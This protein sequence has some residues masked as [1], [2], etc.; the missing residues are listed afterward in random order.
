MKEVKSWFLNYR[1]QIIAIAVIELLILL[2]GIFY[3]EAV[4]PSRSVLL[5]SLVAMVLITIFALLICR[6]SQTAEKGFR[7]LFLAAMIVLGAFYMVVFPPNS[8]PDEIYHFQSSYKCADVL[9]GQFVNSKEITIRNADQVLFEDADQEV[10][11]TH[12]RNVI[13]NAEIFA[14]EEGTTTVAVMSSFDMGSDPPQTKIASALGII[15]GQV[16]G[17]GAYPVYYLG[18]LFN[19]ISFLIF[20]YFAVRLAPFGKSIFMAVCLLPMTLHLATSYSY[21][22]A[23]IGMG[24]LLTSLCLNAIYGKGIIDKKILIAIGV[25][26]FL[27]AP[28]KIIYALIAF[29]VLFIPKERFSSRKV[30]WAV[31]AAVVFIALIGVFVMRASSII[32]LSGVT[33]VVSTAGNGG[34]AGQ[35]VRGG[36]VGTFYNLSDVLSDPVGTFF[37]YLNAFGFLGPWYV[38][39]AVGGSLGWFQSNIVANDL[40]VFVFIVLVLIAALKSDDNDRD[41]SPLLRITLVVMVL[42]VC[43][44]AAASMLFGHTFIGEPYIMGIQG[45]YVLP[46]AALLLFALQNHKIV[47]Q[48][49]QITLVVMGMYSMNLLYLNAIFASALTL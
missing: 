5:F 2:Q 22:V 20:A 32:G 47:Y 39:T 4:S 19:F 48:G 3:F 40:I 24:L 26:T 18:R 38:E 37:L 6:L 23:I 10:S 46:A 31:K 30:C 15:L 7:R 45:R 29:L 13:S 36:Q 1:K 21:D 28:C 12:Y 9:Q 17:L 11:A 43:V 41:I 27:L 14:S 34:S 35:D 49:N 25:V 44:L 8:V 16:L 42:A 33:E